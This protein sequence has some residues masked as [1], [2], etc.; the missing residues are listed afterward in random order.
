MG[1]AI[2]ISAPELLTA[3]AGCRVIQAADII[4]VRGLLVQALST[5]AKAFYEHIGF[6]ASSLDPILKV[7]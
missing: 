1:K 6:D 7:G 5:E 4:G 3:N 2:S